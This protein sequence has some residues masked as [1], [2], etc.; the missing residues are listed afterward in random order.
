M[1]IVFHIGYQEP[2]L[3]PESQ[4]LGGTETV[5]LQLAPEL[6]KH[7][8]EVYITGYVEEQVYKNVQLVHLNNLD[9]LPQNLD[10]VIGVSYANA[11]KYFKD[12]SVRKFLFYWHNTDLYPWYK[13]NKDL[14][15]LNDALT[16]P[17][18]KH[19][20]LTPWHKNYISET[21][22]IPQ[23][24]IYIS[25]N[26]IDVSLFSNVEDI[27][28]KKQGNKF[29]YTSHLERGFDLALEK[30]KEYYNQ[31][32]NYEFHIA[33]P[34]YG[35]NYANE[36]YGDVFNEPNIFFYG[37]L[38]KP[39][40]Y[41]LME[42]CDYWLYPTDYE[43][44]FCITALEMQMNYVTPLTSLKAGL[45]HTV[46][47]NILHIKDETLNKKQERRI[48]SKLHNIKDITI[49]FNNFM[50]I[51]GR[52]KIS[53]LGGIEI[54]PEPKFDFVYIL[55]VDPNLPD[56]TRRTTSLNIPD[57]YRFWVKPGVDGKRLSSVDYVKYNIRKDPDWKLSKEELS[58]YEKT[59]SNFWSREITDG[60][61]GCMLSHI[62]AWEDSYADNR[63]Y[64]IILEHDFFL[65]KSIPWDQIKLLA[66]QGYELIYLGRNK[67]PPGVEETPIKGFPNWAEPKYSYNT[68]AYIL[69]RKGLEK[70]LKFVPTLKKNLIAA[71]EFLSIAFGD[72]LRLDIAEKYKNFPK[73]KAV[74][75]IID[76]M[77]QSSENI[78]SSTAGNRPEILND[79]DWEGWCKKY[80]DPYLLR[81]EYSLMTDEIGPNV[82]EF[83]LFTEK[84]C[85]EIIELAEKGEWTVDRHEYYPTTDQT[86]EMLGMQTIYNRV[87]NQF[88]LPIW[89]WFW[90]LDGK[91]YDNFHTENFIA[92]Y[93]TQNQGS[94]SIHHDASY[95]TLNV[96][97]N[98][99]FVGGGTYLPRYNVTLN[100]SRLGYA[101]S[102][103][104]QITHKHG[105]R[106]V[107]E[108]TRYILVSFTNPIES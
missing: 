84:F 52:T 62:D 16:N 60:E 8:N 108:G 72:T 13:G 80:I 58:K 70:I 23:D 94:L 102:H 81:G 32:S 68:H 97:L 30:F 95:L 67:F 48:F 1:R 83:P 103:P 87:I 107:Y 59:P 5:I 71:D 21:Y 19:I 66:R 2:N 49:N 56:I 4:N 96:R 88:V 74:A 55:S 101:M 79:D 53:N 44:T 45:E 57:E 90:E 22:N 41:Q 50:A 43:E 61:V 26:C 36:V 9:Q 99:G 104:G 29:I 42:E 12:F 100:P 85:K 25:P 89:K 47:H 105:G 11:L 39:E 106:P 34:L 91:K 78:D 63:E 24:L 77:D 10:I 86:M 38:S 37:S 27:I 31:D 98:D 35:L 14:E 76:Y 69:T 73:L 64:T 93:D 6:A 18:Y 51:A 20:A 65:R 46:I 7:G 82:I 54:K 40:L 92:K 17:E 75:P 28:P 33:T 15:M 3:S